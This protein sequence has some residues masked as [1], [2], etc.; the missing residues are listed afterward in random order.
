MNLKEF[1]R[2]MR[3]QGITVETN[4]DRIKR[5]VALRVDQTVVMTTPVD[6]GRARS[7]WQVG[8]G[9][10]PQGVIGAYA[11]G[12]RGSTGSQNVQAALEQG[13][14]VITT[15]P[16]GSEL[17]ITNN[18]PYIGELNKGSSRQAPAG[19][20]EIAVKAGIESVKDSKILHRGT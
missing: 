18:L 20:V 11:I 7:N 17:H 19:F 3:Q 12:A 10:A 15:A 9:A 13:K 16:K 5:K 6:K 4:A 14:M 2:V 8:V 1:A